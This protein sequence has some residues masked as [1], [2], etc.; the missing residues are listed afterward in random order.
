[1]SRSIAQNPGWQAD[2]FSVTKEISIECDP[3][4]Y[5]C[6]HNITPFAQSQWIRSTPS[7][8]T[9]LRSAFILRQ[10]ASRSSK[11]SSFFGSPPK[12]SRHIW[13]ENATEEKEEKEEDDDDNDN[14]DD[15]DDDDNNNN[16]NNNN[17][18]KVKLSHYRPGL[19]LGVPGGWGSRILDNRHMKVVRLSALRSDRLHFC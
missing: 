5:Y 4:I 1:M 16:N 9:Y 17:N 12:S 6:V 11:Q 3:K 7:Y 14:D 18:N 15:D 10:S 8:F 2:S 13:P 19:A